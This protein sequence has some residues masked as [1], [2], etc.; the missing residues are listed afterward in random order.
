M[1]DPTVT[2]ADRVLAELRRTPGLKAAE[3][4]ESLGA[5]RRDV[6]RC[7]SYELVG[8]VQQGADYRWRPVGPTRPSAA[9]PPVAASTEIAK[10][11]RYYLECIGQDMDEGASAF[12][13]S[14]YGE[15][16]YAELPCLPGPHAATDWFNASGVGRVLGKVRQDRAKLVAWLGYPVRLRRH[17]T[18]RWEGFFVEP[19]LLWRIELGDQ[20]GDLP[21]I[22]DDAPLPNAKFL[23]SVAMGDGIQLA[24]ETSRLSDVLGLNVAMADLPEAEEIVERLARIRPDWDWRENL[25]PADCQGGTPLAEITEEGIYN[26]AILLPGERSPFT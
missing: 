23:R 14:K 21:R 16:D 19:L 7:L 9:P 8:K 3:L 1:T 20:G 6:N 15:P 17:R 25:D 22:E 26:R 2:L 5:E 18:L 11:C 10:L 12:A 4:A 13:S 24:E